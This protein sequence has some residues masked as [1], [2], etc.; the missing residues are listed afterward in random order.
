MKVYAKENALKQ[1]R[2][3]KGITAIELAARVGVTRQAI[4]NIEN[5]KNGV[6]P[7][8]C[9]EIV[10]VLESEFDDLFSFEERDPV[11]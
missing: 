7:A 10:R 8:L 6:S 1:A 4:S 9:M 2:F 5:R 3:K 11:I